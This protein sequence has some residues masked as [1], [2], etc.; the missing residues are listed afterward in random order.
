MP[1]SIRIQELAARLRRDAEAT[2]DPVYASL[3]R[4]AAED[5]EAC[6]CPADSDVDQRERRAG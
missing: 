2:S 3:M 5:L 6:S 4:R 1:K